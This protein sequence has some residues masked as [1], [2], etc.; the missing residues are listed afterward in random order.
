MP[1][2]DTTLPT[3]LDLSKQMNADGTIQTVIEM[4][5][6]N[7]EMLD[8]IVYQEGN[9]TIGHRA[10]V[11]TGLPSATWR[12]LN[13]GVLPSKATSAQIQFSC[14]MLEAISE[15]DAAEADLNSNTAQF[16]TNQDVAQLE[17][18]MQSLQTAMIYGNESINPEQITGFHHY[19]NDLSA[20]SADNIINCGGTGSDNAS[21]WL[22][23]WAP[24]KC[25]GI[26]PKGM[27]A[28]LT[29]TA[30][31]KALVDKF[32]P[33][34][35]YDG[36]Y[37]AYLTHYKLNTGLALTDWRTVVRACNIDKSELTPNAATGTNLIRIMTQMLEV[38]DIPL[39][40]T[41]PVFYCSRNIRSILR[42]QM[43]EAVKNSSL[44]ME[45]IAGK[46]VVAFDGIPVRALSVLAADE[47]RIV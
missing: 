29:R 27:P 39:I 37:E 35:T 42:T 23:G 16:L 21:I 22:V 41:R 34:L 3:L 15:V 32:K 30:H 33:D 17:A 2:L 24:N 19:Y 40:G 26:V 31:P 1:A 14:G 13:Q 10:T 6:E 43:V 5:S 11:R 44:T 45:N 18:V 28:G 8:D 25:F 20:A 4:L 12:R 9:L 46:K 38:S 7:Y 47:A 36:K